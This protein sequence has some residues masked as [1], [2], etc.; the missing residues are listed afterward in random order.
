MDTGI[1]KSN[2]SRCLKVRCISTKPCG[3][4][5][6]SSGHLRRREDDDH[7]FS[8]FC[9]HI[10]FLSLSNRALQRDQDCSL[11]TY[12]CLGMRIRQHNDVVSAF[13]FCSCTAR[14]LELPVIRWSPEVIVVHVGC[15][16]RINLAAGSSGLLN[17]NMTER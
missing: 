11:C 15:V 4:T 12:F 3:I 8:F 6:R 9:P 7:I 5:V 16:K 13:W 17:Q 14:I 10:N 2:H 1:Q